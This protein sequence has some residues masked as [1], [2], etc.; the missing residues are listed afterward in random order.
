MPLA[1]DLKVDDNGW[2]R[3]RGGELIVWVPP[4]LQANIQSQARL[5]LNPNKPTPNVIFFG[6][7]EGER[8]ADSFRAEVV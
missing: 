1:R 3:G 8:W 4:G 2:L 5:V 7:F 6:N